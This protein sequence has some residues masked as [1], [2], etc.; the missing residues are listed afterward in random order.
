M[1]KY[2]VEVRFPASGQRYDAY[3]PASRRIHE[4]TELLARIATSLSQG[5]YEGTENTMLLDADTGIPF[6]RESTVH[7]VGIRNASRLILI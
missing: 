4:V 6:D 1:K 5:T 7:D 3:L 2:L